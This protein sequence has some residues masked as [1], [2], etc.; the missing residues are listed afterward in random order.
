MKK[1]L[2]RL[3]LLATLLFSLPASAEIFMVDSIW[4]EPLDYDPTAVA[5]VTPTPDRPG[6][7]PYYGSVTV[8]EKVT[9]NGKTYTVREIGV[10][11]FWCGLNHETP[12][13]SLTLPNTITRIHKKGI[14]TR[15]LVTLKL[16][17]GLDSLESNSLIINGVKELKL[18]KHLKKIKHLGLQDYSLTSLTLPA[19]L[20]EL[21]PDPFSCEKLQKITVETGNPAYKM[22][23]NY[24]CTAD[25]KTL[26]LCA[27]ADGRN[28]LQLPSTIQTIGE[29]A[30]RYNKRLKLI[31]LPNHV[32][33]VE[34]CAFWGVDSC[35]SI[36]TGNGVT[37]I[38]DWAFAFQDHV[39]ELV[40][41]ENVE[42]IGEH[43][44]DMLAGSRMRLNDDL[45]ITPKMKIGKNAFYSSAFSKIVFK[46]GIVEIPEQAFNQMGYLRSI[47]F[48]STLKRIGKLAFNAPIQLESLNF[49]E[50]L[51][52]IGDGAFAG[53]WALHSMIIPASVSYIGY[54]AFQTSISL[55]E[56]E[57]AEGN[58]HYAVKDGVLFNKDFTVLK[59]YP[60]MRPATFYEVPASVTT[61][62]NGCFAGAET[63]QEIKF[64]NGVVNW[65]D[66]TMQAC[67]GLKKVTLPSNMTKLPDATF[68]QT[69]SLNEITLPESLED[70]G[71]SAFQMTSSKRGGLGK[72]LIPH[73]VKR[74][75]NRA[76]DQDNLPSLGAVYVDNAV[77]PTFYKTDPVDKWWI[78][79]GRT[80][81]YGT[82]YVPV[83]ATA[84]YAQ[85]EYWCDFKNIVE[86]PNLG[87]YSVTADNEI[88][89]TAAGGQLTVN[90]PE[91]TAIEV[92]NTAGLQVWK[93]VAPVAVNTLQSGFY[94]VRVGNIMRKV[95]I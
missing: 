13:V 76:F 22:I 35:L 87:V 75:G 88:S 40:L 10:G 20:T 7:A 3:L 27:E 41:G 17:D 4:Y 68:M 43:A 54:R 80:L 48:P 64:H 72:V 85:A 37:K 89:V 95:K 67:V 11:A 42:Y 49:P 79:S 19:T 82:L 70:I 65:G 6:Y 66:G 83:G 29:S 24:L 86:D 84:A 50:G 56:F 78:F 26:V 59:A 30:F 39:N 28:V 1:F 69:S 44:F 33:T 71:P 57:V 8:P 25:G 53:C 45:V 21:E 5:V 2:S 32:I 90:A 23:N 62:E 58:K 38:G 74:I 77:P 63:L 31:W 52:Y 18:P 15:D 61:L 9:Y 94:I 34:N 47:T 12:L 93:G 92:Y 81:Y 73:N 91:G 16:S 60:C 14:D 55:L 46:E 36:R 51:E